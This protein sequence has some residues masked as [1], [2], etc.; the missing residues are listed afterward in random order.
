MRKLSKTTATARATAAAIGFAGLLFMPAIASVSVSVSAH[1]DITPSEVI[2]LS[3]SARVAE[4]IHRTISRDYWDRARCVV[5][6]PELKKAA[7]IVGGEYGR[8]VM[9]CR[10]GS[11]WSAPLFMQLGK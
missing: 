5:V 7:F 4:D 1:P 6:I 9:S 10:S 3:G 11:Q 8:G 2:R